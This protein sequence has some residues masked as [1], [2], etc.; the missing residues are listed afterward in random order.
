MNE[1]EKTQTLSPI[2]QALF[3][4]MEL[5]GFNPKNFDRD[6]LQIIISNINEKQKDISIDK[7]REAFELGANRKLDIDLN[8]Y[9]NFNTLYVANVL[10]SYRRYNINETKKQ[11]F[12]LP[13]PQAK[14]A[15][16]MQE[17]KDHFEWLRDDVFLAISKRNGKSG[18]FPDILI[19]SFKDIYDY[20]E[21]FGMIACKTGE[22]LLNR[23]KEA[24][25]VN[26]KVDK[27]GMVISQT[28]KEGEIPASYYR[29]EVMDYFIKN[30]DKL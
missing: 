24:E 26:K 5:V 25:R 12:S 10:E 3:Y 6:S 9:Q 20:M 4:A 22:A 30:K 15:W 29:L 27:W 16:S 8:T 18:E 21:H 2:H 14:F 7:F 1:I 13:P 11:K 23:I 28:S 19:C 17:K